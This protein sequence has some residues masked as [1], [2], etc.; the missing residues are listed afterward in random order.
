MNDLNT[1]LYRIRETSQFLAAEEALLPYQGATN[2]AA[3]ACREQRLLGQ[4]LSKLNSSI[5]LVF[6]ENNELTF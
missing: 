4:F 6:D 3:G 5:E 1:W 2:Q